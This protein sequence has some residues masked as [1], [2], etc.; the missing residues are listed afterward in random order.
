MRGPRAQFSPQSRPDS[1]HIP[2][3]ILALSLAAAVT[4]QCPY[5]NDGTISAGLSRANG[6]EDARLVYVPEELASLET[7]LA[8]DRP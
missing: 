2:S 6:G 4:A 7:E 3:T 8:G 5:Y 1:M